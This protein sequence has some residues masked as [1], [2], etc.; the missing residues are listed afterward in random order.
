MRTLSRR[1]AMATLLATAALPVLAQQDDAGV[2]EWVVGFPAGGG[3]DAPVRLLSEHM[4]KLLGRSVVVLNKP[5]ASTQVAADY[6]LN[7]RAGSILFTADF[8]TL[9]TNAFL[10]PKLRYVPER[11]FVILGMQAR[12]PMVL[13]GSLDVPA[14]NFAELTAWVKKAPQEVPYGSAGAATPHHLAA[15]L[16][17]A[18]TGL[19][20]SHIPYKG[21]SPALQDAMARQIPLVMA[22]LA[23]AQQHIQAGKVKAF[24][25]SSAK[26]SNNLP[27]VPSFIELGVKD[28]EVYAWQAVVMLSKTPAAQ[29]TRLQEALRT[30]LENPSVKARYDALGLERMPGSP[31]EVSAFIAR[32]QQRWGQVIKANNIKLD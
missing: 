11:D 17:K 6:V 29:V 24:G 25:I 19:R 12:T 10:F 26:R 31:A 8:A 27:D 28:Y 20:L 14:T 21:A 5:G 16:L 18:Q 7:A 3:A 13:V 9:A 2:I 22:D 23:T 15:E 30:A 1:S 32:E 4:S